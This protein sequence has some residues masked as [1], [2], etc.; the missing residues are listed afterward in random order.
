MLYF[1]I[2]LGKAHRQQE[3][4]K[5]DKRGNQNERNTRGKIHCMFIISSSYNKKWL[6][7]YTKVI[8]L[9]STFLLLSECS[10]N[11]INTIEK[12]NCV[13]Y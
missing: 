7:Y 12:K 1:V 6:W 3:E 2:F 5:S 8:F 4:A 10:E 11:K 13:N 9:I